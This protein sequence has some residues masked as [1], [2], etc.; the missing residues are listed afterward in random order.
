[1]ILELLHKQIA[2]A[3]HSHPNHPRIVL[4]LQALRADKETDQLSI[5]D[6]FYLC[7]SVATEAL[8]RAEGGE[9]RGGGGGGGGGMPD[10]FAGV[11]SKP[12]ALH[13]VMCV[14]VCSKSS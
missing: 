4:I 11:G 8:M 14:L 12:V 7:F 10:Y 1:M 6:F 13:L 2:Q 3:V 9:G 5:W